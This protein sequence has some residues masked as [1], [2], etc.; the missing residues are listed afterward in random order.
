MLCEVLEWFE[1]KPQDR[2]LAISFG[3]GLQ[4]VNIIRNNED[5]LKRGVTFYPP[6]W[7][8]KDVKST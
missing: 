3:R 6:S 4:L 8:Q 5:D 1:G 7:T 2:G